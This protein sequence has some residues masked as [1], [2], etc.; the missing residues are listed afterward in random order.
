MNQEA[1]SPDS[2]LATPSLLPIILLFTCPALKVFDLLL[3]TMACRAER[4][5][6]DGP[7]VESSLVFPRPQRCCQKRAM[8][9]SA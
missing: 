5:R 4:R 7:L 1:S 2:P 6:R 3:Q 8:C 9:V